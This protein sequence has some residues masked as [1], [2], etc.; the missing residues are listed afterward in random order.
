MRCL[1]SLLLAIRQA[2]V[3]ATACFVSSMKWS[4]ILPNHGIVSNGNQGFPIQGGNG[5]DGPTVIS[6]P[7]VES[8]QDHSTDHPVRLFQ[9]QFLIQQQEDR[10]L[11]F[12]AGGFGTATLELA[13]L[14]DEIGMKVN[15][16]G[17]LI[18]GGRK[19]RPCSG[20]L[21]PIRLGCGQSQSNTKTS[22]RGAERNE[23]S[24]VL[25]PPNRFDRWI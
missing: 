12:V 19:K 10:S 21:E 7:L 17:G 6:I 20:Q 13:D 8:S 16:L 2:V 22:G 1:R 3:D 11:F 18:S 9:P 4:L 24:R 25:G 15:V 23:D 14:Q 5:I